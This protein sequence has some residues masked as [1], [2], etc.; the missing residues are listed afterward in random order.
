MGIIL[1]FTIMDTKFKIIKTKKL[2]AL[3]CLERI[4]NLQT[5]DISPYCVITFTPYSGM[6]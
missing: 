3:P 6:E 2:M 4:L 1:K 5:P